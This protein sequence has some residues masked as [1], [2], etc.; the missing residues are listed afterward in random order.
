[1][2]VSSRQASRPGE[3]SCVGC[4]QRDDAAQLLR[5]VARDGRL[6]IDVSRRLDGRGAWAHA[7]Q[8]CLE[9]AL[10]R[11]GFS[12][13]LHTKVHDELE[14]LMPEAEAIC[15]EDALRGLGLLRR[16]GVLRFGRDEGLAAVG[17]G[18]SSALW[19]A[20]DA[21][22]R[23]QRAAHR[24]AEERGTPV[25]EAGEARQLGQA[26]GTAPV[27]VIAL[28][29]TAG[30]QRAAERLALWARLRSEATDYL[31]ESGK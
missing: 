28:P 3:R 18:E 22:P 21:A 9:R 25:I 11:G 1:L 8:G 29:R 5:F 14:R 24:A 19:L 10:K 2:S 13:A 23:T 31:R 30:G 6:A 20:T 15:A 27:A 17:A 26:L 4:R 16:A 7:R 12:Y